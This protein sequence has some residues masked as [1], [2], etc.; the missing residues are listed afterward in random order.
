MYLHPCIGTVSTLQYIYMPPKKR[1]VPKHVTR[2]DT[3]KL[4]RRAGS[5]LTSAEPI[6]AAL[7]SAVSSEAMA[8]AVTP[9]LEQSGRLLSASTETVLP[10]R[11]ETLPTMR[12][13]RASRLP[14]STFHQFVSMPSTRTAV[15][16]ISGN[17]CCQTTVIVTWTLC[18]ATSSVI[19]QVRQIAPWLDPTPAIMT[20]SLKPDMLLA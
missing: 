8:A 18:S 11:A 13:A 14:V 10:P 1:P 17:L 20:A 15:P 2:M 12:P 19:G 5:V 4:P 6:A 7:T 16:P 9:H 3:G